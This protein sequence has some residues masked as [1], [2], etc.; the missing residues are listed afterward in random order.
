MQIWDILM[1]RGAR[2]QAV[3]LPEPG[4]LGGEIKETGRGAGLIF[5]EHPLGA[6]Y[7]IKSLICII[8]IMT[9]MGMRKQIK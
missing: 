9:L 2:L 8:Y 3:Y 4:T 1:L 7:C 5:I 6:R